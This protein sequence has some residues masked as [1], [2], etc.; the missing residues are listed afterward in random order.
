MDFHVESPV[1][2]PN[3]LF[4]QPRVLQD[5]F[6]LC[7]RA[8]ILD[9][10]VCCDVFHCICSQ[11]GLLFVWQGSICK[12]CVLPCVFVVSFLDGEWRFRSGIGTH[13]TLLF[14][15]WLAIFVGDQCKND[16]LGV[17]CSFV[18]AM[19][20]CCIRQQCFAVVMFFVIEVIGLLSRNVVFSLC[21]TVAQKVSV[22]AVHS[23]LQECLIVF[24]GCVVLAFFIHQRCFAVDRY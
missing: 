20:C 6:F 5:A 10:M 21:S 1:A 14:S 9:E 23:H 16:L 2:L 24:H 3:L 18:S 17:F 15:T 13:S 7:I 22:F 11:C 12:W 4:L 8:I 19:F